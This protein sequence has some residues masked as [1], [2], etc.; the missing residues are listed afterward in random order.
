MNLSGYTRHSNTQVVGRLKCSAE[1]TIHWFDK[2]LA[3]FD[4][5]AQI[6]ANRE[7]FVCKFAH[8]PPLHWL[9]AI[10]AA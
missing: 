1:R 8:Q 6:V 4:A 9:F 2:L 5:S 3:T 7:E 10:H